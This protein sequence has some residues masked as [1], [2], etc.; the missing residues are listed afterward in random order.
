MYFE[1]DQRSKGFQW[2]FNFFIKLY[3]NYKY[4]KEEYQSIILLDEPGVYLHSDFQKEL[5]E[6]LKKISEKNKIFYCTHLENLVNPNIISIKTIKIAIREGED[7][8]LVNYYDFPAKS[9]ELGDLTPL[10]NA[11]KLSN[12]PYNYINEKLILVEGMTEVVF[13]KL[14]QEKE[15]LDKEIKIIPSGGASNLNVL[16]SLMIGFS[17]KYVLILDSDNEGKKS[18]EKAQNF[19]CK[20]ESQK[21]ILQEFEES[22]KNQLEDLYSEEFKKILQKEEKEKNLKSSIIEFYYEKEDLERRKKGLRELRKIYEKK[23]E[24]YKLVKKIEEILQ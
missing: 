1:V 5:L 11:L 18:F 17:N 21:W 7:I 14:L 13:F 4:N 24:L 2:F 19:F 6:I 10:I 20:E 22:G 15:I 3:Y 12:Y 8:K 9:R 16:L 23:T